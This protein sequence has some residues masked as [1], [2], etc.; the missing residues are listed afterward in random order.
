M[1]L[2]GVH[3]V[4]A[5][6]QVG[7]GVGQ[8]AVP[9]FA[10]LDHQDRNHCEPDNGSDRFAGMGRNRINGNCDDP[11]L[12]NVGQFDGMPVGILDISNQPTAQKQFFDN[13]NHRR[14]QCES[15]YQKNQSARGV[16]DLNEWIKTNPFGHPIAQPNQIE[17]FLFQ[18]QGRQ[19]HP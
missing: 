12:S 16:S 10:C 9:E 18:S 17:G 7:N 15:E 5:Q 3:D 4:N 6:Q 19:A 8:D 2:A 13:R 14:Q 11:G 1:P